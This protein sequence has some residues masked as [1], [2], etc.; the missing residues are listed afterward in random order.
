MKTKIVIY[1]MVTVALFVAA[2]APVCGQDRKSRRERRAEEK[3]EA[4]EQLRQFQ[5]AEKSQWMG[6]M[7]E[8]EGDTVYLASVPPAWVFSSMDK[9][10]QES[11]RQ[12]YR[13]VYNFNKVYPY[14]KMAARIQE[15]VDSTIAASNFTR[16][17]EEQ[18]L[19]GMQK[20]LLSVFT[21]VI[22]G[23]TTSQGKL[24]TRLIDRE[25]GKT[26][27]KI[28]KE[29]RSGVSAVF[30]QGVARLFGQ[31]LKSKYDPTGEDQVTEELV[32]K[33]ESGEF[34]DLYY[35]IFFEY[36]KQTVIPEKYR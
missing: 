9:K 20:E 31:N 24:V 23:I 14:A 5:Q 2:A 26:G 19:S 6:Y 35:S 8:E 30:W 18:Y 11:Y 16:R 7:V 22:R 25:T 28:V 10:K 17:Q 1:I 33:W 21:P 15:R 4:K 34:R 12:Y 3:A 32:Q 13:L 36:P 27:Y 29:Y